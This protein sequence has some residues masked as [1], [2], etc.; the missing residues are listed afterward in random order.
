MSKAY[1]LW[2][3]MWADDSCY[4]DVETIKELSKITEDFASIY[5][6]VV[7]FEGKWDQTAEVKHLTKADFEK[8][9]KVIADALPEVPEMKMPEM[10]IP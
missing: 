8:F 7:G 10:K 2:N 6:Y 4:S 3:L 5:S 9:Q 1:D